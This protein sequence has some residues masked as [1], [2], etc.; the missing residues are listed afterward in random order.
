M[1]EIG[2][3]SH[4]LINLAGSLL[5]SLYSISILKYLNGLESCFSMQKFIYTIGKSKRFLISLSCSLIPK[6]SEHSSL[7]FCFLFI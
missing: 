6:A 1:N 3:E 4:V 7:T 2:I 5:E